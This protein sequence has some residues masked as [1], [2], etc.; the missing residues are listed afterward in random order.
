MIYVGVSKVPYH[1]FRPMKMTV[2]S[3]IKIAHFEIVD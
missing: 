1:S 2:Q 3:E